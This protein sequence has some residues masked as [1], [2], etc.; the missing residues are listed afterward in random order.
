MMGW[1]GYGYGYGF[2]WIG[3]LLRILLIIIFLAL[4]AFGVYYLVG[5]GKPAVGGRSLEILKERY[6][7]GEISKEEYEQIKQELSKEE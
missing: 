1:R 2:S 7:K 5:A 4:I 3:A 6:A